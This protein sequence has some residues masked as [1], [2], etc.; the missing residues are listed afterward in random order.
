MTVKLRK[1]HSII[2]AAKNPVDA[3][4]GLARGLKPLKLRN[5]EII[6]RLYRRRYKGKTDNHYLTRVPHNVIHFVE[7]H[8]GSAYLVRF[9]LD[10][11]GRRPIEASAYLI[12]GGTR[13]AT[14]TP[15][16]H[17]ILKAA[18]LERNI[19][20][21]EI[22]HILSQALLRG[23][24]ELFNYAIIHKS[25]HAVKS[26]IEK[27]LDLFF[28]KHSAEIKSMLVTVRPEFDDD[29][30]LAARFVIEV[31]I[32]KLDGKRIVA[33]LPSLPNNN[34]AN[35]MNADSMLNEAFQR[36]HDNATDKEIL[37]FMAASLTTLATITGLDAMAPA[38]EGS[39]NTA[40]E[41]VDSVGSSGRSAHGNAQGQYVELWVGDLLEGKLKK[42]HCNISQECRW[43]DIV[44]TGDFG[45]GPHRYKC[46]NVHGWTREDG[47][48]TWEP[49]V[50][51]LSSGDPGRQCFSGYFGTQV[52]VTVD[53]IR[54]NDLTWSPPPDF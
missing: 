26:G 36:L 39:P 24:N 19:G 48:H 25:A 29:T 45:P 16:K 13:K 44:M 30:M 4:K 33:K 54:S 32:D 51:H 15:Y 50:N 37:A 35:R 20:D 53:G 7:E 11:T 31:T 10:E 38:H 9:V 1:G 42:E 52:Y 17:E 5:D 47:T 27:R 8:D 2:L 14:F 49:W 3:A 41:F 18:G 40:G 12:R 43:F 28:D 23:P 6:E 22:D 46:Y 34:S 21:Y